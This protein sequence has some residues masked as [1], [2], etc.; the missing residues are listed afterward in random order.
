MEMDLDLDSGTATVTAGASVPFGGSY[1]GSYDSGWTDESAEGSEGKTSPDDP[2]S[3]SI[4]ANP[5]AN[6][7]DTA[8]SNELSDLPP[9]NA[10]QPP[11]YVLLFLKDGSNFAVSDYWLSGGKLHYVTSYGGENAIDEAQLDLQ[12][13]V[14]ENATRGVTSV[15]VRSRLLRRNLRNCRSRRTGPKT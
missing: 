8:A 14:N 3:Y 6:A 2:G 13:T 10:D 1:P 7:A 5:S 9:V 12:R 11:T 4:S 15:C